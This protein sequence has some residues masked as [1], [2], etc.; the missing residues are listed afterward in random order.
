LIPVNTNQSYISEFGEIL[1][2]IIGGALFIIITLFVSKLIR[3][4][5]PGPEK[6]TSYES[7][8]EPIGSAWTQFNIRFYIVALIFILFEVEII[9]LFPWATVF[10]NKEMMK[11]TDGLWGWFSVIEAV[12]FIVILAL[13][14]VYAWVKG[15][16]DWAKP[17]PKPTVHQS[18]VPKELYQ[19]INQQYD[20]ARQS[21]VQVSDGGK[22]L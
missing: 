13:G 7:G 2:F 15:H 19:K 3:P 21:S 1:L 16:L 10:A 17:D 5:R 6:L 12:I 4:D 8:E 20:T 22:T 9:F 14:L 18:P 11:Q